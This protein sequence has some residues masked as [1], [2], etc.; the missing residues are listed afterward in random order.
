MVAEDDREFVR[1]LA[2]EL[3]G[4]YEQMLSYEGWEPVLVMRHVSSV[5]ARLTGVRA[6]L[7]RMNTSRCQ[8]IT[9]S[10]VDPLIARMDQQFRIHSRLFEAEKL[11][12]DVARGQ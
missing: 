3:D 2:Q 8:R 7:Q 10:E 6:A 12:W 5:L 9:E 1:D 4:Y 11:E